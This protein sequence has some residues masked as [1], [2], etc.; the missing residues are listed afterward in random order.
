MFGPAERPYSFVLD[1]QY[2]YQSVGVPIDEIERT[3]DA[4]FTDQ[5]PGRDTANDSSTTTKPP[6]SEVAP[7]AGVS[8]TGKGVSLQ[9]A[10]RTQDTKDAAATETDWSIFKGRFVC[11]PRQLPTRRIDFNRKNQGVPN[12]LI[13]MWKPK[14]LPPEHDATRRLKS[15]D[16]RLV[17]ANGR[18]QPGVVLL[19]TDQQLEIRNNEAGARS[20]I[21]SPYKNQPSNPLLKPGDGVQLKF[22]RAETLPFAIHCTIV[23]EAKCMRCGSGASIHGGHGCEWP[24]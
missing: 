1:K 19:R 6:K 22:P 14:S 18:F 11:D 23:S 2:R 16:R 7:K 8:T 12:V 9:K 24:I 17:L 5:K 21:V 4:I 20:I 10:S 3:I 13:W 15:K